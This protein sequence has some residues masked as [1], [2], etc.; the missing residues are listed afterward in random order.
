MQMKAK[1]S[2]STALESALVSKDRN[3]ANSKYLYLDTK[4][5]R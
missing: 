1:M 2:H 5:K 4:S 3:Y